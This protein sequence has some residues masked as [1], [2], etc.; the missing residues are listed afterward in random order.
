LF[1]VVSA[2][3]LFWSLRSRI[4]RDRK[5]FH[6]FFAR[7]FFRIAPLFWVGALFYLWRPIGNYSTY[8]P[9]GIG[10]L[11]VLATFTFVHGWYP[12]TINSVVPGGWS[13]GAEVMFYLCIPFLF[14]R[15]KTLNQALAMFSISTVLSMVV[16]PIVAHVLKTHYPE[17][18]GVLIDLFVFFSFPSQFPVFCAG[19]VLYFLMV[20]HAARHQMVQ[21]VSPDDRHSGTKLSLLLIGSA[22]FLLTPISFHINAAAAFVLLAW[23]LAVRPFRLLVNPVIRFIG[24]I[25]Y[26][27][28]IWHFVLLQHL[29]PILSQRVHNDRSDKMNGAVQFAATYAVLIVITVIVAAVSYYLIE[30]PGQRLGKWLVDRMGWGEQRSSRAAGTV[31][32]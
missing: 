22:V 4:S 20:N 13:I 9:N 21:V 28:Y 10:W 1:F 6:A 24:V 5:P 3:T 18:W 7:R 30:R 15:L 23:G 31:R 27:M 12:T 8:A 29:W 25:S 26:S 16:L 14:A 11:H 17:S 2:F 32:S 19:F